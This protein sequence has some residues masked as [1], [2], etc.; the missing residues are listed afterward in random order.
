MSI[1]FR[2][3]E[4]F[5]VGPGV[6]I[7]NM[8]DNAAW[9]D[10]GNGVAIIDSLDAADDGPMEQQ[11]PAD[12]QE[13]V[14]KPIKWLVYT[15]CHPDHVGF[16]DAWRKLGA[17]VVVHES[18]THEVQPDV[19]FEST[20]TIEGDGRQIEIE[21]LGGT[22]TRWDSVVYFPWARVLHIADLFGWGMIPLVRFDQGKIDLLKQ[23]LERVLEYDADTYIVGHG[24]L[25]K[26]EHLRRWIVYVD[27]LLARAIPLARE[28][29]SLDEI[30]RAIPVPDD[31]MD[32]WKLGAWKHRHNLT[33][34]AKEFGV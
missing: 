26:P 8:V 3:N 30:E 27:D 13:T 5:E 12:I 33:L 32:W 23:H 19:T 1:E 28:G 29:K 16:N 31:M 14:G 34:V 11:I 10:L 17:Q 20:H 25:V 2:E 15:H 9:A 24:P 6:W 4:V 18:G 22:H 7:R 21:W